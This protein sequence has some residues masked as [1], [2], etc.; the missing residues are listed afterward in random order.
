MTVDEY[1]EAAPEPQR[2]TLLELRET[3]R[4]ILPEATETISYGVP[5]FKVAGKAIAG[6]AHAKRHCSYFPHS[7]SVLSAIAGELERYDWDKGTLR[8]P[9]DEVIPVPLVQSLVDERLR[10]LGLA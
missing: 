8:F 10:Q 6:Y 7:G 4:E 5:A 1:L 3:L 2:S 9:V